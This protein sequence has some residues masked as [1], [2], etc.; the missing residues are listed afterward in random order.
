[1]NQSN[2]VPSQKVLKMAAVLGHIMEGEEYIK[3]MQ[4]QESTTGIDFAEG[5]LEMA[6][7]VYRQQLCSL[8]PE[9]LRALGTLI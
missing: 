4:T 7:D 8:S 6:K 2:S 9:E 1:M 5:V 3:S